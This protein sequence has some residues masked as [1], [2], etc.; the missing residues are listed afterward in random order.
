MALH[1]QAEIECSTNLSDN[2]HCNNDVKF[3]KE[4]IT[5]IVDNIWLN[6]LIS[7]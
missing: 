1:V 5:I 6:S 2:M 7:T 3:C 4:A